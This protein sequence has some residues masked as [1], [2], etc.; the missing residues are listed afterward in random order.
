MQLPQRMALE[1]SILVLD[2]REFKADLKKRLWIKSRRQLVWELE[3]LL[4][5]LLV[6]DRLWHAL[7]P[8]QLTL[9]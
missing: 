2:W 5:K 7:G 3:S 1:I 4:I 8:E 9:F 6:K